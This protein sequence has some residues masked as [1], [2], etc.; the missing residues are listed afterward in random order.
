MRAITFTVRFTT[1]QFKDQTQRLSRRTYLIPPPSAVAGFLGAILGLSRRELY[2][3]SRELLTGAELC[4][5]RGWSVSI[6]RIFKMDR[7]MASLLELLRAYYRLAELSEERRIQVVEDVRE[8][9]TIKES[10]E[11]Y[12][13]KYKFAVASSNGELID[14]SANRLRNLDFEYDVFGG[15]DYNFID[16][17]GDVRL[18]TVTKSRSGRGYCRRTDFDRMET[19]SFDVVRDI[20]WAKRLPLMMPVVFLRAGVPEEFIQ[21]Y[22]ADIL[23]REEVDVVD[24]GESK[25]FVYNVRPF[26]AMRIE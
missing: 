5:L 2:E 23:T 18:A 1:A 9:L 7:P 26:L 15:N 4:E 13:P 14:R 19:I 16:E 21:V 12:A 24:D 10:E 3:A 17:A 22:G 8:L 20:T 11:L 6:S 25:V